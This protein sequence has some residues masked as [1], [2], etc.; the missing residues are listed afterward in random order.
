MDNINYNIYESEG[1]TF[2]DEAKDKLK[3]L[4]T[5]RRDGN[6]LFLCHPRHIFDEIE[7]DRETKCIERVK[8]DSINISKMKQ[9]NDYGKYS[10][11]EQ[12]C[13]PTDN[14]IT[15]LK[16][17]VTSG[18][19]KCQREGIENPLLPIAVVEGVYDSKKDDYTYYARG[20]VCATKKGFL[21]GKS[22]NYVYMGAKESI[23]QKALRIS[24]NY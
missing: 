4:L 9:Y 23:W 16:K 10:M 13:S 1:K 7:E 15:Y 17:R 20:I 12:L 2:T 11:V 22:P 3:E 5:I 14:Q 8:W 24:D 21:L 18:L 6:I 19:E